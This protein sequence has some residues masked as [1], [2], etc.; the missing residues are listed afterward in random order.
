MLASA[1]VADTRAARRSGL[2]GHTSVEGAFVLRPCRHVHT[3]GMKCTL[4]IA[5][6]DA[7]GAVLA[8]QTLS[9]RR[10]SRL[11]PN[12]V[13]IIEAEAGSFE[14]WGLQVGDVIEVRE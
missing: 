4:D 9:P 11:V 2:C 3:F 10:L 5:F 6:C 1:E 7:S 8:V 14:R 13:Q 12:T